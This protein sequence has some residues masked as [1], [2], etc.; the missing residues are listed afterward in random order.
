MI[1]KRNTNRKRFQRTI[2]KRV[3]D[4]GMVWES[5]IYSC[6][7]GKDGHPALERLTG[8]KIYISE[9]LKFEFYDLVWFWDNQSDDTRS[10]LV[11]W[12]CVSHKVIN[13]L[14][15]WIISEKEKVLSR[16]TVQNLTTEEPRDPDVQEGIRD[17]HGS[18]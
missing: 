4:L 18:M 14:F 12:I 17:Y 7:S 15:Y 2:P 13:A 5:E 3:W 10:M 11:R 1:I 16:T 6:T 9:W 8:D